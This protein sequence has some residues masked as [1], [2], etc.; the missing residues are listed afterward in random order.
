MSFIHEGRDNLVFS[1]ARTAP[2]HIRVSSSEGRERKELLRCCEEKSW[3]VS[4][5]M[6]G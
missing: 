5:C 3:F 2:T 6:H 4:R 1:R